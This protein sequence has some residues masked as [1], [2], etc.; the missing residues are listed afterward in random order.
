MNSEPRIKQIKAELAKILKMQGEATI[1]ISVLKLAWKFERGPFF[2]LKPRLDTLAEELR[3]SYKLN[4]ETGNT[5][6]FRRK[7]DES[8]GK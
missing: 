4:E 6:F 8:D 1:P 2:L 3:F 7:Q 5:T